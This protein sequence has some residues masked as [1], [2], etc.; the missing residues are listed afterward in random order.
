MLYGQ[1]MLPLFPLASSV[2]HDLVIK[3]YYRLFYDN[4][5]NN[6][7]LR[8]RESY[9]NSLITDS[10]RSHKMNAH[11]KILH[12]IQ[13]FVIFCVILYVMDGVKSVILYYQLFL[14]F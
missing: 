13:H 2:L 4:N 1:H 8:K 5:N 10:E 11:L 9:F 3:K 12:V 6:D 7:N 14:E